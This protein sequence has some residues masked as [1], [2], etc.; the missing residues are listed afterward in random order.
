MSTLVV[1]ENCV[2]LCSTAILSLQINIDSLGKFIN[3][4]E[5]LALLEVIERAESDLKDAKKQQEE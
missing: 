5:C 4:T 2:Y 1:N 3:D